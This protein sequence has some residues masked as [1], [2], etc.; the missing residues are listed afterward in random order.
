MA[1]QETSK[2][3]DRILFSTVRLGVFTVRSVER[4]GRRKKLTFPVLNPDGSEKW[5][6]KG[7]VFTSAK[8]AKEK[9]NHA[10]EGQSVQKLIDDGFLQWRSKNLA[11][12]M[13]N[14]PTPGNQLDA[15]LEFDDV[16][17]L[18]KDPKDQKGLDGGLVMR[19]GNLDHSPTYLAGKDDD[20]LRVMYAKFDK[21]AH[22]EDM[23]R[24]LL[25]QLLSKNYQE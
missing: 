19:G 7:T 11:H 21:D 14:S 16:E 9:L 24:D 4:R 1:V 6:P 5:Y 23:D 22:V 13:I 12:R 25:V 18:S 8:D 10:D 2:Q 17:D 3:D 20:E 15:V